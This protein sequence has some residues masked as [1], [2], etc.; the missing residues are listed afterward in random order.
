[1]TTRLPVFVNRSGGTAASKGEA[2]ADE[3]QAAFA[4]AGVA[5]DLHLVEGDE[6]KQSV[7][8]ALETHE[9][10]VV[11]GGDGTIG[12]AAECVAAR[13]ATLGILPLGTRNHLARE[14][15]IP[16]DLPGAAA[17]IAAGN[18]RKID[19]AEVNDHVFI[20]N[21]SVGI[22]PEMVRE[23]D[24]KAAPKWLAAIGASIAAL[25]RMR[26]HRLRIVAPDGKADVV[27]PMLFV[28]NNRYALD[29]GRIGKRETLDGGRLAVY[30][31]ASRRRLALIGFALRTI[32]GLA[33]PREDFAAIDEAEAVE[34]QGRSRRVEIA[35]DGEVIELDMPL[36]FKSRAAALCVFAPA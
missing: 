3:L 28:G 35:L 12:C 26:H 18:Q 14:L 24:A 30:A 33:R 8:D 29:A 34:V 23:R 25:T 4:E 21:A 15:G 32:V 22:Y 19:L 31:V 1:M 13:R 7:R 11:G 6:I 27:T 2:L 5:I 36:C 20:N 9:L 16:L 17:V 10:V